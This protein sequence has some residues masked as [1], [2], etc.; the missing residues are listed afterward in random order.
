MN[1][2]SRIFTLLL[3][4]MLLLTAVLSACS[5]KESAPSSSPTES[6]SVSPS[7]TASETPAATPE[8]TPSPEPVELTVFGSIPEDA[9]DAR[10]ASW[11]KGK[12][13]DFNLTYHCSCILNIPDLKEKSGITPDIHYGAS[14]ADLRVL[15]GFNLQTD[16]TDLINAGNVDLSRF[17]P[18]AIQTAK[19]YSDG[20]IYG[21]QET[22][23]PI[24]L[25]YN[26]DIFDKFKVDY[27][28][29]GMTWDEL[30][31]L[32]KK[33]TG[34]KDGV[35]YRGLSNFFSFTLQNNEFSLPIIDAATGKAAV[36]NE[37]WKRIFDNYARFY[38]IPGNSVGFE[39]GNPGLELNKFY[40]QKNI[41]MLISLSSS[42]NREGFDALNWDMVA[43]PT[44][45]DNNGV[46]YQ[47]HPQMIY[48]TETTKN[49][50]AALKAVNEL[51]SD[52]AQLAAAKQGRSTTLLNEDVR[53]AYGEDVEK[54]K[55]K[56]TAAIYYN[57]FAPKPAIHPLITLN[58]TAILAAEFDKVIAGQLDSAAALKSAEVEL[59]KAIE[60]ELATKK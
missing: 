59:N 25:F 17:D 4:S 38:K 55:G 16:L 9:F 37:S 6:E 26:K 11:V 23:N 40:E 18:S 58:A 54:L 10:I 33:V 2:K 27:P 30:Y 22:G 46:G 41:A 48:I 53:K 12:Y 50:E 56:H 43:A 32:A 24:V 31:D 60:M 29:D 39:A 19:N 35:A 8:P 13:P 34:K 21:L 14:E 57:K 52:E 3:V 47:D 20:K 44:F 36:N 45:A 7:P 5:K 51:L 1:N 15:L 49:K 28:K 42:I